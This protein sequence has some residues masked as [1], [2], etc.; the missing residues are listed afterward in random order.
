M[1][2]VVESRRVN[3]YSLDDAGLDTLVAD[4]GQPKYRA[5]QIKAW[6][7][8]ET[9]AASI[10]EMTNLPKAL[11]AQ[12]EEHATLGS[13]EVAAEQ[14]S[15]DGTRKR[16]WRCTDGSL[17]ESVLMPYD[18]RRRTACISSQVGGRIARRSQATGAA[19]PREPPP[20]VGGLR[21][22]LH[23]L[24]HRPDGLSPRSDR[25]RDIR[26]GGTICG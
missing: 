4:I 21:D 6:L 16:L 11:R 20:S 24:R 26:A 23:L 5:K 9:P 2:T 10:G 17:I 22:G 3:L 18:T 19:D 1:M 8:G 13:M 7:Y 25:G 12:L 14:V 15:R